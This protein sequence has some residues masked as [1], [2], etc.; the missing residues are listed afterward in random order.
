MDDRFGRRRAVLDLVDLRSDTPE[1][2][3]V[4]VNGC[5]P[6]Q[7]C[8]AV[9]LSSKQSRSCCLLI[10]SDDGRKLCKVAKGPARRRS[11]APADRMALPPQRGSEVAQG[12]LAGKVAIVTGA[13]RGIGKE[14]AKLFAAEGA[15]VACTARTVEEGEHP[16]EGSLN[17]TIAEIQAAGGEAVPI[18]ADV[19]QYDGLRADRA[20]GAR[21]ARPDRR[22]REQRGAHL[23]HPD[24]RVPARRS[25]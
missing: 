18:A 22:A 4:D 13:S 3:S 25:G 15:R 21:G 14:I 12:K 19:S 2:Q 9:E 20:R 6:A 7:A 17:T 5:A 23:L 16:L 24:R 8:A 1:G 11:A 10:H